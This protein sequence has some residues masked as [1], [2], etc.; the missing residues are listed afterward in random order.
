MAIR[1]WTVVL[2]GMA[3]AAWGLSVAVL[4]DAD[5]TFEK[6]LMRY[7]KQQITS[8]V[9]SASKARMHDHPLMHLLTSLFLPSPGTENGHIKEILAAFSVNVEN[10]RIASAHVLL[11]SYPG[12]CSLLKEN[13][14]NATGRAVKH[15]KKVVCTQV[16]EQPTY[17]DFFHYANDHMHKVH[18][19]L[20]NADVVFDETLSLIAPLSTGLGHIISVKSPPY[21]GDFADIFKSECKSV[22]NKDRCIPRTMSWDTYIFVPPLPNKLEE[23]DLR[24]PMNIINAENFAG[25]ALKV[26]GVNLTNPC[27]HVNAFHWHCFAGKMHKTWPNGRPKWN[28]KLESAPCEDFPKDMPYCRE[29]WPNDV[30]SSALDIAITKS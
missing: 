17:H 26:S 30:N 1:L 13:M 2:F 16:H 11:E 14:E 4:P 22:R 3:A 15:M 21:E 28:W 9:R 8:T 10:P 27:M 20:S 29:H 25:M 23:Y 24:F 5:S 18:V 12:G 6:V 19:L 7:A